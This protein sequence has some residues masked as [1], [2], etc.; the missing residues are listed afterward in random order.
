MNNIVR[1]LKVLPGAYFFA[2]V[3]RLFYS[4]IRNQNIRTILFAPPGHFYSPLPNIKQAKKYFETDRNCVT[5]L[6]G[7]NLRDDEQLALLRQFSSFYDDIPFPE[8][9][10][11]TSRYYYSNKY[12]GAGDSIIV[13]CMI[14]NFKPANIIEIGSGFS[15]AAM[16]D[17][18]DALSD[19]KINFTF[20]EPNA[21]RLLNLLS[22]E[23]RKSCGI[24]ESTVQSIAP[25]FFC[26]LEKNDILF[27]DSSHISKI[28]SD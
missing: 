9:P 4:L 15:S 6:S 13:Y 28:G 24:I 14:R 26:H 22:A 16:L 27:I 5:T 3:L 12:F 7:I 21:E 19:Y 10:N 25:D 2:E 8:E 18:V 23:D 11:K 20:I 17:T 1:A